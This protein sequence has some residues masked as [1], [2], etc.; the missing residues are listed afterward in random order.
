MKKLVSTLN[1]PREEWLAWRR[2]GIG[3]SDAAGIVGLSKWATPFSVYADKKGLSQEKPDN[4]RMRQGRDLEDYAARRFM[5]QTGKHVRRCNAILVHGDY[6][7]L[8]ANV[9]RMVDGENAGLECKTMDP[10]SSAASKLESGIVPEQYYCQCQHYM[11]VTGCERWYLA[12]V[13]Y[14]TGLY[15]FDIPRNEEDIAALLQAEVDFWQSYV[16]PGIQPAPDSSSTCTNVVKGLYPV[17][18]I[19][20]EIY[21]PN[22]DLLDRYAAL[23]AEIAALEQEKNQIYNELLHVMQDAEV[24]HADGWRITLKNYNRS[25]VDTKALKAD[26]PEIA[27]RYTKT[28]TYRRMTVKEEES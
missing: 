3:G 10:R 8:L 13:V 22:R 5:E 25:S 11:M 16:I 20:K 7:F 14:G 9:D 12:I 18:E 17:S 4:E 28:T 19:G 21:I 24:G 23:E 26:Y 6:D 27:E 15:I 2:K 1:M